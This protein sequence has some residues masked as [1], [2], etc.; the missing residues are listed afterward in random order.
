MQELENMQRSGTLKIGAA[1]NDGIK[2]APWA[3]IDE[4]TR[5]FLGFEVDIARAIA[6]ILNVE[7]EF[8]PAESYR[9]I[10]GLI[11]NKYEI[12][13]G[14]LKPENKM[15]GVIFS[16]PYYNLTQRIVIPENSSVYDL[17]DLRGF[18]VGVMAKSLGEFIIQEENKNLTSPIKIK[19]YNDILDVFSA[20]QFK[21]ISAVFIDSPVAL[22]YSKSN[23]GP[24]LR[25]SDVAYKSGSYAIA[26]KEGNIDLL[27]NINKALKEINLREILDKYGLWD[28][29]QEYQ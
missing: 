21:E 5:M 17:I 15:A 20:L 19:S 11:N 27:S 16:S 22:W 26:L 3:W 25:V 13:I 23:T 6:G 4:Q 28:D 8:I 14:A 10:A 9:I 2:G 7:A 24:K 1:I 29:A 12:S 18:H